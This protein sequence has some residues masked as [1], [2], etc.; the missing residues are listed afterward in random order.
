MVWALLIIMKMFT[1]IYEVFDYLLSSLHIILTVPCK[2]GAF[3][4]PVFADEAV[5]LE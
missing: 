5:A 3:I 1:H 4:N 2:V